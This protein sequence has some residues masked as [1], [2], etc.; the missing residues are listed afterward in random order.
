MRIETLS[1]LGL[2]SVTLVILASCTTTATRQERQPISDQA[3]VVNW[4]DSARYLR[5]RKQ[6]DQAA[7]KLERALRVE[8]GNASLWHELARVH[9]DQGNFDQAIQFANKS[10][11]LTRDNDLK[12]SNRR[13]VNTAQSRCISRSLSSCRKVIQ[14]QYGRP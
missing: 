12:T 1:G 7:V 2:V 9:L 10:N 4:V 11:A 8:P 13:L 6:F 14:H 5:E 3:A